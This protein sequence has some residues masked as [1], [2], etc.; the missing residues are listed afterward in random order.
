MKHI[1]AELTSS[2]HPSLFL[3]VYCVFVNLSPICLVPPSLH[4]MYRA[5]T[6]ASH[7]SVAHYL[8][9]SF[10]D[11]PLNGKL[12]KSSVKFVIFGWGKNVELGYLGHGQMQWSLL[13]LWREIWIF[14]YTGVLN[15]MQNAGFLYTHLL[16]V[17]QIIGKWKSIMS[18]LKWHT[19]CLIL[20]LENVMRQTNKLSS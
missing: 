16:Y 1:I 17:R 5:E 8:M 10:I 7:S 9:F 2:L 19:S 18:I 12:R 11:F 14:L 13:L 6:S 20:F 3:F 15:L 4:H